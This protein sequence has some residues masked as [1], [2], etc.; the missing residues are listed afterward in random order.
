[1]FVPT[2]TQ[3]DS[4]PPPDKAKGRMS[5]QRGACTAWRPDILSER[6]NPHSWPPPAS[7]LMTQTLMGP[8]TCL[9]AAQ[10]NSQGPIPGGNWGS[11]SELCTSTDSAPDVCSLKERPGRWP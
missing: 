8:G 2:Q 4:K 1:M 3:M 9:E 10:D 11:M 5:W 7:G 6:A